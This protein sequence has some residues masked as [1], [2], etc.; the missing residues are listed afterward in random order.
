MNPIY[1]FELTANGTTRQ[2]FPTYGDAVAIDYEL[3]QGEQFYRSAFNGKLI[4]QADDYDF[5]VSKPFETLFAIVIYIS[6]DAGQTWAEY[7]RGQFWKTDCEFDGDSETISVKPEVNDIYKAVLDGIEKEYDIIPLN[8]DIMPVNADKR[9][10]VQVYVPGQSVIACFLSGMWWEQECDAVNESDRIEIGGVS[11]PALT[12]KYEFAKNKTFIHLEM[13]GETT[14]QIPSK[15]N[16]TET[17]GIVGVTNYFD[18]T[19]GN[20]RY[21]RIP[22]GGTNDVVSIYSVQTGMA[23]WS[24]NIAKGANEVTLHPVS[25]QGAVGDIHMTISAISVY[26]RFLCDTP[27]INGQTTYEL[28][29]DDLVGDNRNYSRAIGYYF[30]DTI[31]FGTEFTSTPNQWGIYQ[32]GVYY[33]PPL[34]IIIPEMF[35]V[36][37]NA[38]GRVS[39]WFSFSN[40]DW[41]VEES[42]REPFSMKY[43]YPLWSVISVLLAQIAP[44]LTF[45]NDAL[46][47]VFFFGNIALFPPQT[48]LITPKSNVINSGYDQPAQKAPVTL[49]DIFDMLRDCFRCY[50]FI[51]GNRLRIEHIS[52]FRNGGSYTDTPSIG[53]DLTTMRMTR[54]GKV[55]AFAQNKYQFDKPDMTARYEFGWMDDVTQLFE[56]YPIDILSKYVQENKIEQVSVNKF[57]SDIDYILLNPGDISKDGF[58]LLSAKKKNILSGEISV[59]TRLSDGYAKLYEYPLAYG[60]DVSITISVLAGNARIYYYDAANNAIGEGPS[61]A[62]TETL[63]LFVPDG[64][65]YI[66]VVAQIPGITVI[67]RQVIPANPALIYH[68]FSDDNGDH[69]LQNAYVSFAWLQ[70]YYAYDMPAYRYEINGEQFWADGVKKLKKQEVT[71]PLLKEPDFLKLVKTEIGEGTIRKLSVNLSSRKATATLIYDTE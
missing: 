30:P 7:W 56:G 18:F 42:G 10:L 35:P 15:I 28:P 8:P 48:L 44:G 31:H 39:V 12:H 27:T 59:A 38:W 29:D 3:Q 24:S 13:A 50:W 45:Q 53:I 19:D 61:F 16:H 52:Y 23:L 58:V 21:A 49:R 68:N 37:R 17:P 69:I 66:G 34:T 36:A 32:P 41:L 67:L 55:W 63:N 70:R 71:F 6:H 43:T 25:G 64:T 47:S 20:Y 40:M 4:F 5:I 57:T 11:Y 46:H 9:P 51:E 2:A 22:T 62:T 65:A 54:N 60:N 1:K 33:K 14:P 26:S